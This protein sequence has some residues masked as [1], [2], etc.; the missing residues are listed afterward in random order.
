MNARTKNKSEA[1]RFANKVRAALGRTPIRSLPKG[2]P[3]SPC[4]CP[5]AL[6][7]EDSQAR[8]DSGGLC[9]FDNPIKNYLVGTALGYEGISM[10]ETANFNLLLPKGG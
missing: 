8:V 10:D 3:T 6:A 1:L 9:F 2:I 7:I 4:N 5:V